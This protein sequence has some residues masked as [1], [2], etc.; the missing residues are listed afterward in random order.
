MPPGPLHITKMRNILICCFFF[1]AFLAACTSTG[2]EDAEVV[3]ESVVK[4]EPK[5]STR[6]EKVCFNVVFPPGWVVRDEGDRLVEMKIPD[7]ENDARWAAKGFFRLE[8]LPGMPRTPQALVARQLKFDDTSTAVD[9][10]TANGIT[11]KVVETQAMDSPVTMYAP[12][13]GTG[14]AKVYMESVGLDDDDV[15]A[16]LESIELKAAP[17]DTTSVEVI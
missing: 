15:K 7:P 17:P 13:P 11:W 14:V 3:E 9:D 16:I 5:D 6:F 1:A 2:K 8:A 4:E 10:V 12:L